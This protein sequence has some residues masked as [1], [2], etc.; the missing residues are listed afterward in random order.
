MKLFGFQL[1]KVEATIAIVVLAIGIF[2]F[3]KWAK[4]KS[5]AWKVWE[6][7]DKGISDGLAS[8]E[9]LSYDE[10]QFSG[11]ASALEAAMHGSGTDESAIY[12]V[13]RKMQHTTDLLFLIKKFGHRD[14]TNVLGRTKGTWDLSQWIT[15]ELD[16]EEKDKLNKILVDKSIR[17]QF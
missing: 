17:Y 2:I 12:N 16:A 13:F 9:A 3:W 10:L 11:W 5:A 7:L 1:S 15:D 4:V 8:G 6:T 14:K